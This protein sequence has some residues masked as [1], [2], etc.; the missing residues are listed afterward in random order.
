MNDQ[1]QVIFGQRIK[2]LEKLVKFQKMIY[3][4]LNEITE[5]LGKSLDNYKKIMI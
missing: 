4:F 2:I 3:S 5:N 1:R